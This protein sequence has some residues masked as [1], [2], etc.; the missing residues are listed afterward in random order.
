[1]TA[2]TATA[3]GTAAAART[4]VV[5]FSMVFVWNVWK[6]KRVRLADSRRRRR[7]HVKDAMTREDEL[8]I[9]ASVSLFQ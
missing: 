3:A 7:W 5:S 9:V 8:T 4:V 2:G 6:R 1:M